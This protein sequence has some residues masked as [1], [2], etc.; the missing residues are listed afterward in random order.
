MAVL[1]VSRE[2]GSGG[3]EIGRAVAESLGYQ[4]IDKSRILSAISA[5]GEKWGEWG[6]NLDEHCPTI[7]EKYDWS[8]RGFG[9]LIQSN[10]LNFA[11][12]DKVVII[13]RG[14][15]FLLKK[16][17]F[18]L[19]IRI[20]APV[21]KRLENIAKRENVDN[22]TARW[23]IEKTDSERSCFIYSLYG[24]RWDDPEQYD[25]LFDTGTRTLDEIINIVKESLLDKEKFNTEK[26]REILRM[27]ALAA[28]VKSV[29]LTD[30]SF[31]V[32]MLDVYSD[33]ETIILRG[34]IHNPKEHKRI[35]D[36]A[37]KLSKG[38]PLKC[39][40]HYRG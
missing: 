2:Y 18:A 17:P 16:I 39:E 14:G 27:R 3:R 28:E 36:I 7:W 22:D 1:T 10:I 19:R 20:V 38:V 30:P 12:R 23:L 21:E 5:M 24:R 31:F 15:N 26:A 11:L 25:M 8:F 37:K 29:I 40:L 13:G 4:Y 34:T 6:K 33:G 35:E 32:P 9:A